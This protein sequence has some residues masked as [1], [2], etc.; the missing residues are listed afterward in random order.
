MNTHLA[1]MPRESEAALLQ[2]PEVAIITEILPSV[3]ADMILRILSAN[4]WDVA[5]STDAALA[6]S[7][8]IASEK[9]GGKKGAAAAGDAASSAAVKSGVPARDSSLTRRSSVERF[10]EIHH[11]TAQRGSPVLLSNDFLSPPRYRLS[12]DT[13]TD[14]YVD[15]TILFNRTHEKL[16]I[17]IETT[18]TVVE[19]PDSEI[20][21]RDLTETAT[22]LAKDA[23]VCIGDVITGVDSTYFSPGT[24][25]R[26]VII[27]LREHGDFVSLHFRRYKVGKGKNKADLLRA[28]N[29]TNDSSSTSQ[30]GKEAVSPYHKLAQLL[31]EQSIIS[32]DRAQKVTEGLAILKAR[33]LQWDS[34]VLAERVKSCQ[35]P[36]DPGTGGGGGGGI[37]ES[38]SNMRG[39][40]SSMLSG[41]VSPNAPKKRTSIDAHMDDTVVEAAA[42]SVRADRHLVVPDA[43]TRK[44]F[45]GRMGK[46]Q[47]INTIVGSGRHESEKHPYS[48]KGAAAAAAN[49]D[50]TAIIV[51]TAELR[52]ALATRIVRAE[53]RDSHTVYVIVVIDIR[54]GA[55]WLV[56]RRFSEFHVFRESLIA[57][58]KSIGVVDFPPKRLAESAVHTAERLQ[59]LQRFLRKTCS[60][61]CVNSLHPS[62]AAVQQ[63]LQVF[64]DVNPKI[65][66]IRLLEKEGENFGI[67]SNVQV[68]VHSTM[69]M[70]M[71]DRVYDGFLDRFLANAGPSVAFPVAAYTKDKATEILESLQRYMD[72]LQSVMYDGL[73]DDCCSIIKHCQQVVRANWKSSV[74]ADVTHIGPA[75]REKSREKALSNSSNSATSNADNFSSQR[76]TSK[77][78][79]DDSLSPVKMSHV[80][81]DD[82]TGMISLGH[83]DDDDDEPEDKLRKA[84]ISK[85]VKMSTELSDDDVQDL[86]RQ[87][88]RRQVEIEIYIACGG[89][90]MKLL[91]HALKEEEKVLKRNIDALY[92]NPQSFY[93]IGMGTISPTS[94]EDVVT[95]LNQFRHFSLPQDRVKHLVACAK[96]IPNLYAREHLSTADHMGADEFLPVF[97]YVLVQARVPS[98]LALNM[99]MQALVDP[100][101]RCGEAGYYLASMEAAIEHIKEVD[102]KSGQSA[103]LIRSVSNN[104]SRSNTANS[105]WMDTLKSAG[106]VSFDNDNDTDDGSDESDEDTQ[107]GDCAEPL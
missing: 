67:N 52:P 80:S 42:A 86:A 104:R 89:F 3:E 39:S 11:P 74:G 68:F 48:A 1:H 21:V 78:Q 57:I 45:S 100:E 6:Y 40:V 95:M 54:S 59:L 13:Y 34:G 107:P 73:S 9:K 5:R 24:E 71:L 83:I 56:R 82:D 70:S 44:S 15:F 63:A 28:T 36:S 87:T 51:P 26:E 105:D 97:I 84:I 69:Q 37:R 33:V 43:C 41:Q 29:G 32:E 65:E 35:A 23:G 76:Q 75:G 49:K 81:K 58:R 94:W 98:L 61:L 17:I 20:C 88:I 92:P 14:V 90:V 55:E 31:L 12:V 62:T 102:P 4:N 53:E 85:Q 72:N 47:N 96:E 19:A 30:G 2:R 46:E 91:E 38:V 16:G 79:L 103:L 64:L 99:E 7:V 93:G 27:A 10:S 101:K 66:A 8:L 50:T 106:G 60:L 22:S 18:G 77:E 25:I